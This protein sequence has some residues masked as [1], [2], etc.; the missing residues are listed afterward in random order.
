MGIGGI[1]TIILMILGLILIVLIIF[2]S[3]RVKN[4]GSAIVGTNDVE[5]FDYKKRGF[6]KWLHYITIF[7]VLIF[8]ILAFV[9]FFII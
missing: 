1:L 7:L 4:L 8:V 5:L 6:A 9:L 2:Q 3:G